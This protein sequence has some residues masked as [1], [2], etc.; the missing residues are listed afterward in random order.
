MDTNKLLVSASPH[1]CDNSATRKLMGHVCLALLPL[2]VA[3]FI[4]FGP[5]ALLVEGVTVLACVFFEWAYCR[6]MK[7][8]NPIGD[9]SAIVT[10]LIL[11]L[12]LPVTIPIWI[13]VIGAFVAIVVVKQLFG[14]IGCNFANPALVGRIVLAV[15]FAG[16]MTAYGFPKTNIDALA[17][18]TP[19]VAGH[20]VAGKDMLVP[21]LLG[22]HGGVLGETCAI[23]I[24]LGGV[25]L[26]AMRVISPVIPLAYLGTVAAMSALLGQD[27]IL[28]LLSGGLLF[29]AFFMATDYVTS[30]FTRS[31]KLVYAI[32]LGVITCV[33]RFYGNMAE[34]VSYSILL[35]NLFV[36]Y[37]NNLTRQTVL[38]SK[39]KAIGGAKK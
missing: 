13:A 23:S 6:L 1:I 34:G 37:I 9:L 25:Y 15:G 36:P 10:G 3:S 16:R 28:Q 27:V 4:I 30:P 14:G 5:R 38:G 24:V 12:N 26:I 33:I 19:L 8:P 11:A 21:L 32:G 22:T 29:G 35:M 2:V 18:A 39:K 7:Q 17:G 31:G 20:S